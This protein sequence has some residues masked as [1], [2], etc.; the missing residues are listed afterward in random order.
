[1]IAMIQSYIKEEAI[2]QVVDPSS[3]RVGRPF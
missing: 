2:F 1:M 3:G